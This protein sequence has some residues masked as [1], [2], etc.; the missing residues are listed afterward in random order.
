MGELETAEKYLL[1]ANKLDAKSPR[2]F[3]ELGQVYQAKG[4]KDKAI[5]A[6]YRALTLVFGGR[7]T[8]AILSTDNG[9]ALLFPEMR[10]A[11]TAYIGLK[12]FPYPSVP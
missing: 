2:G 8:M 6:Y 10:K 4:D 3:F 11:F 12:V 1:E 5:A 7:W 9:P